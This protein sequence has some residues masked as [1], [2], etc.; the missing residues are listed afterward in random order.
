MGNSISIPRRWGRTTA[1]RVY[2]IR[3]LRR[4]LRPQMA[5]PRLGTSNSR[6]LGRD[7]GIFRV[8]LSFDAA[9]ELAQTQSRRCR[10][11]VRLYRALYLAFTL[12]RTADKRNTNRVGNL[13][14]RGQCSN[15]WMAI[16]IQQKFL[17]LLSRCPL[18]ILRSTSNGQ[19]DRNG[20][21]DHAPS[22]RKLTQRSAEPNFLTK[23]KGPAL[24]ARAFYLSSLS[25]RRHQRSPCRL[26]NPPLP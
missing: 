9:G 5:S 3:C 7:R 26:R 10:L 17:T 13:C 11:P 14:H 2:N 15:L 1:R 18:S 21:L 19:S 12:S 6:C 23:N 8:D 16:A 25:A 24:C 22:T 20:F 4:F